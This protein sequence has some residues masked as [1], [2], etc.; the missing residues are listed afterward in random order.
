[1]TDVRVPTSAPS[2]LVARDSSERQTIQNGRLAI[3]GIV[4]DI[5]RACA[6]LAA[7]LR[8]SV[9]ASCPALS[10]DSSGFTIRRKIAIPH[11]ADIA[12]VRLG[13]TSQQ[14]VTVTCSISTDAGGTAS[15]TIEIPSV[16]N[17]V[18]I[19]E[20]PV[21]IGSGDPDHGTCV[22]TITLTRTAGGELTAL[23]YVGIAVA[24]ASIGGM[25]TI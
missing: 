19:F 14:A 13:I 23:R 2:T 9:S 6:Y 18:A 5:E 3:A 7:G 10:I 15:E 12:I 22:I 11:Y 8:W 16:V 21:T 1:M 20:W 25:V 4:G 24:P 17:D